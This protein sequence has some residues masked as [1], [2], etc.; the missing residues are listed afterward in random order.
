MDSL[1]QKKLFIGGLHFET[2]EARLRQFYERWGEVVD[3]VVMIDPQTRRSRGF[4]FVVFKSPLS[5]EDALK[6]IPHVIDGKE[7]EP[8]RAT[9]KEETMRPENGGCKKIFVGG[10]TPDTEDRHLREY[11]AQFGPLESATVMTDKDT[12]K[13]RGFAFVVFVDSASV[14]QC[15]TSRF[16][17]VNGHQC[18]VKK[19]LPRND[20]T[21]KR[22]ARG[23]PRAAGGR[24]QYDSYD[25]RSRDRAP[26]PPP[27]HSGY[28]AYGN[29]TYPSSY[30]P[31]PYA[32]Y[33]AYDQRGSYPAAP[34]VGPAGYDLG[35]AYG[36]GYSGG[37][38]KSSGSHMARS[39]GPYGTP[40]A[41]G[42]GAAYGSSSAPYPPTSAYPAS[43]SGSYPY[44][45]Y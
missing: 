3:C 18:E 40:P 5:A 41:P 17:N 32:R 38:M 43:I 44:P 37:P 29:S 24:G 20:E 1:Q 42:Y 34:P 19:A 31:D 35:M 33:P 23:P 14:D 10:L 25:S 30:P 16:H 8:K 2:T 45:G 22:S 36:S 13:S 15:C 6:S 21:L 39:S 12:Q 9:P 4:G 26:M 7:V 11:F 28:D 27:M